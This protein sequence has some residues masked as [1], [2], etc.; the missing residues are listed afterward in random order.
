MPTAGL[1]KRCQ[2]G[3]VTLEERQARQFP[4]EAFSPGRRPA[5]GFGVF[6]RSRIP[7]VYKYEQ[8]RT[9]GMVGAP[10]RR[11][12]PGNPI[13]IP[14]LLLSRNMGSGRIK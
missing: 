8:V 7:C 11:C 1:G 4:L 3:T 9:N 14:Q 5:G 2:L 12:V 6:E 13:Y 10:G